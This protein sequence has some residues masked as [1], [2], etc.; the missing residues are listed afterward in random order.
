MALSATELAVVA[1]AAMTGAVLWLNAVLG[2][3]MRRWRA[4]WRSIKWRRGER[5]AEKLLAAGGYRITGRQVSHRFSLAAG[6]EIFEASLRADFL[7]RR[8]RRRFVAEA[9]T[10]TKMSTL[11]CA[12]TRRQVLEYLIAYEVDA[13]LLV[14]VDA[15][16]ITEVSLPAAVRGRPSAGLAV[17]MAAT[18]LGLFAGAAATWLLLGG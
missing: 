14:D 9:K 1:G 12:A 13:V 6:G 2:R 18:L 8:G 10:G 11:G 4:R 16:R 3:A 5:R 15:G 17:T 7:A